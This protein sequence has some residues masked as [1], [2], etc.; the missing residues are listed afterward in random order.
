MASEVLSSLRIILLFR[1]K[2]IYRKLC[3]QISFGVHDLLRTNAA[4]IHSN[5]DW[6]TIFTILQ[7]YGAGATSPFLVQM[8]DQFPKDFQ[9]NRIKNN[10][11]TSKFCIVFN[12]KIYSF[13]I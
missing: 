13:I 12:L 11:E 5:D 4:N 1:K 6:S 7:V 8:N 9:L 2:H 3:R 10:L